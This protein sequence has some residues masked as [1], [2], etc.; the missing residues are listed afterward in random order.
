MSE[1]RFVDRVGTRLR[2]RAASV[3]ESGPSAAVLTGTSVAFAVLTAVVLR[4]APEYLRVLGVGPLGIGAFGSVGIGAGVTYTYWRRRRATDVRSSTDAHGT[5]EESRAGDDDFG[6]RLHLGLS[7]RSRAVAVGA[8]TLGL[9][10]WVL[11]PSLTG[12]TLLVWLLLAVGLVCLCPSAP[13]GFDGTVRLDSERGGR[14]VTPETTDA[15]GSDTGTTGIETAD[16][17]VPEFGPVDIDATDVALPAGFLVVAGLL[18]LVPTFVGGF[19]LLAALGVALGL[20]ALAL[21]WVGSGAEGTDVD[22][23]GTDGHTAIGTSPVPDSIAAVR[24]DLRTLSDEAVRLL[25]GDTL[26][27]ATSGAVSVFLVI[28]VTTV[29]GFG[30]N[31]TRFGLRPDALFAVLVAVEALVVLVARPLAARLSDRIGAGPVA[32]A[33]AFVVSLV[34]ISLVNAPASPVVLI[35][36][37]GAYGLREAGRRAIETLARGAIEADAGTERWT[38]GIDAIGGERT[39]DDTS[40]AAGSTDG[41]TP[42]DGDGSTKGGL[43]TD[44][45]GDEANPD[46]DPGAVFASY[47]LA[48]DAAVIPSALVGGALFAVSPQLAFGLATA[49]GLLGTREVLYFCRPRRR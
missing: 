37:F 20:V 26:L 28:T 42:I 23:N 29:L 43:R 33:G 25:L 36:V 41:A 10:L 46:S 15:E 22:A 6:D 13:L 11:A 19:R 14:R 34:P 30:D 8:A 2:E 1:D 9:V 12:S 49:L 48:R 16:D 35:A 4:Y 27:R 21:R 39:A 32:A 5:A 31:T 44:G 3:R 45:N 24:A 18:A 47:R 38:N 7:R 17:G 40:L